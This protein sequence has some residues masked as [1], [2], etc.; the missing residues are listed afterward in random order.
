MTDREIMQQALKALERCVATCFDAYA[1]E[2]VMSKPE[3]FVNQ[4]IT[5]LRERLAQP[6]QTVS[7]TEYKRLQ[8]LVTSQGIRLMEYESAQPEQEPFCYHDGRNIVGKEF[9]DHSDVFPLYTSPNPEQQKPVRFNCTVI[10]DAHLNG[11]PLSQW[12]KQ[13]EMQPCA[14]RNCGSTNPNL[15]S[16]EC[17]EDY[18]KATGM[19]Q[20]QG[21]TDEKKVKRV[22]FP[23]SW[24][25]PVP[26]KPS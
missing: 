4:N 7:M 14:G 23:T 21:L 1:H 13:H 8:D 3:H 6:E 5:S 9:A 15:H 2:Q 19:N 12:G 20:W 10:D 25:T 16:A 11:V 26:L 24:I 18:E 17:F 22:Y